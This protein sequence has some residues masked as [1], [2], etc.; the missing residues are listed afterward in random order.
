MANDTTQSGET[1]PT[2]PGNVSPVP[3]ERRKDNGTALH[4]A[5]T[6]ATGAAATAVAAGS[7]GLRGIAWTNV[8]NTSALVLFGVVFLMQ[9]RE[10]QTRRRVI[11][12]RNYLQIE[13]LSDKFTK[14]LAASRDRDD[15]LRARVEDRNEKQIVEMRNLTNSIN[16]AIMRL[17]ES[18]HSLTRALDRMPKEVA[19]PPK[20]KMNDGT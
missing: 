10:D 19:P 20:M 16:T 17:E 2:Y 6:V 3:T 9:F 8:A 5:M 15:Q 7:M 1:P 12:D 18:S 11:E 4:T 14:E 13:T